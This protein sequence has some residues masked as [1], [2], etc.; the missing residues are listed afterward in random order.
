MK[1]VAL[2]YRGYS[3]V[4]PGRLS[5]EGDSRE[6]LEESVSGLGFRVSGLGFRV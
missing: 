6:N 4:E 5:T 1:R 3:W 2:L